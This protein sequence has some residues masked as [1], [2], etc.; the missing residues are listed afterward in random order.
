M[1]LNTLQIDTFLGFELF[2][3]YSRFTDFYFELFSFLHDF[4]RGV[5]IDFY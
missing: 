5:D 3:S 2:Y 4:N 1:Q